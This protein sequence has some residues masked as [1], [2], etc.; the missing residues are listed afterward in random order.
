MCISQDLV[1]PLLKSSWLPDQVLRV[2]VYIY[3]YISRPLSIYTY[4]HRHASAN[5][6]KHTYMRI[7][8]Y[9]HTFIHSHTF[10]YIHIHLH[11]FTYIYI[12]SY[13][14]PY[15]HLH[16]Y[17]HTGVHAY[18]H[19]CHFLFLLSTTLRPNPYD[20]NQ[21]LSTQLYIYIYYPLNSSILGKTLF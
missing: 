14:H 15:I 7:H 3:T 11:T 21:S 13:I 19:D 6:C 12:H 1:T 5:A 10:T 16:T 9:I 18:D 2:C 17:I 20:C 4:A 8:T